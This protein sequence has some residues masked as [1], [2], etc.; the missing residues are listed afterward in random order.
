MSLSQASV[1]C[2]I[3]VPTVTKPVSESAVAVEVLQAGLIEH[4]PVTDPV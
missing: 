1:L 2:L 4:H 3:A